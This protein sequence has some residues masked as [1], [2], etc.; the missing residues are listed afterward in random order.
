M[1]EEDERNLLAEQNDDDLSSDPSFSS[2]TPHDDYDS[3]TNAENN[4]ANDPTHKAGLIGSVFVLCAS[5]LGAGL[6][7][8]P[9]QFYKIGFFPCIAI[10]LIVALLNYYA[11]YLLTRAADAGRVKNYEDVAELALPGYGSYLLT[12]LV[13][14]GSFGSLVAF[15]DIIGDI[16]QAI[17]LYVSPLRSFFLTKPF[18]LLCFTFLF[19]FPLCLLRNITTLKYSSFLATLLLSFFVGVVATWGIQSLY[20]GEIHFDAISWGFPVERKDRLFDRI[21]QVLPML[22]YANSLFCFLPCLELT[23]RL[24]Y[25][26]QT[27]VLPIRRELASPTVTRMTLINFLTM[28]LSAF[29]YLTIGIFGYFLAPGTN[30]VA[31][32]GMR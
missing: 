32:P 12:F 3:L 30:T 24:A 20:H 4:A 27:N 14:I 6:L 13:N 1:D 15:L 23:V 19:I 7:T 22:M 16:L 29:L 17:V 31:T 28:S 5:V 10:L 8:I 25:A 9:Q 11:I 21:F 2:H 18:L 26:C